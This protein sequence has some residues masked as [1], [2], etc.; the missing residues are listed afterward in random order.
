[1]IYNLY[2]NS[3][4][5]IAVASLQDKF[6][7]FILSPTLS[8]SRFDP[9]VGVKCARIQ[10]KKAIYQSKI[11]D[12]L[13]RF[14]NRRRHHLAYGVFT[15]RVNFDGQNTISSCDIQVRHLT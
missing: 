4:R 8:R 7:I 6:D 9:I 15:Y 10:K 1:V 13:E 5:A 3:S 12:K 14:P 11:L 2:Y